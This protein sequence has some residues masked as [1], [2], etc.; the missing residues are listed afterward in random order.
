MSNETVELKTYF[1][2]ANKKPWQSVAQLGLDEKLSPSERFQTMPPDRFGY[3][4]AEDL[5]RS[6]DA[7]QCVLRVATSRESAIELATSEDEIVEIRCR[8]IKEADEAAAD[9]KY[10]NAIVDQEMIIICDAQWQN[11]IRYTAELAKMERREVTSERNKSPSFQAKVK[12][13]EESAKKTTTP[14]EKQERII[15]ES[16]HAGKKLKQEEKEKVMK[17]IMEKINNAIDPD[18]S[19]FLKIGDSSHTMIMKDNK[20][21]LSV[22]P[23]RIKLLDKITEENIKVLIAAGKA[24]YGDKAILCCTDPKTM[25]IAR[26]MAKANNVTFADSNEKLA[27]LKGNAVKNA[28]EEVRS[29]AAPPPAPPRDPPVPPV[30][31]PRDDSLV[32]P[33]PA[34][35]PKND[36][37]VVDDSENTTRLRI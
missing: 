6:E 1:I 4:R 19:K 16:A 33:P 30:P 34:V 37:A 23:E 2:L 5:R 18:G 26:R 17:T 7:A 25:E 21:F 22:E 31:P 24:A 9:A 36:S 12:E 8:A 28:T 27:E 13:W 11:Q 29:N 20:P 3:H 32:I 15:I 14:Q 10:V 35:A